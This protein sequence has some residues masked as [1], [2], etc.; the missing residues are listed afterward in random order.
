MNRICTALLI[1]TLAVA[2]T[3]RLDYLKR[4]AEFTHP[5]VAEGKIALTPAGC[6][7]SPEKVSTKDLAEIRN[8]AVRILASK[9]PKMP[10]MTAQDVDLA[11]GEDIWN[12]LMAYTKTAALPPRDIEHL[13]TLAGVRFLGLL[14]VETWALERVTE[15][16]DIPGEDGEKGKIA[17]R[18]RTRATMQIRLT[19]YDNKDGSLA[20]LGIHEASLP[21][22]DIGPF[23]SPDNAEAVVVAAEAAIKLPYSPPPPPVAVAE[24]ILR[25][26][27]E[28]FPEAK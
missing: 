18:K 19:V 28:N 22:D 10:I 1:V 15:E 17:Y 16:I 7:V 11:L 6:M 27:F 25:R 20:W 9:R 14:R 12:P 5:A 26:F 8:A 21:Q 4:S 24:V 2:C 3:P 23:V 13:A